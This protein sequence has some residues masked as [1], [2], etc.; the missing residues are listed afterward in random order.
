MSEELDEMKFDR[1]EDGTL[2]FLGVKQRAARDR[3]RRAVRTDGYKE[4]VEPKPKIV[5]KR[6]PFLK[7]WTKTE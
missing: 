6:V 7:F 1:N 2:T 4:F 3:Q 5:V